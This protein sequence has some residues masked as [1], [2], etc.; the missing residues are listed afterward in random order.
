MITPRFACSQTETSVIASIYCPAIRVR[1]LTR[2]VRLSRNSY[3]KASE[4]EIHV[5]ETLLTVHVAPYF[6]RLNFPGNVVEDDASSAAYDPVSGYLTVTLTKETSGESFPDLDLLAKL[7]APRTSKEN[8]PQRPI[9]EVVSNE[10]ASEPRDKDLV[11][12]TGRLSL[13]ANELSQEQKEILEGKPLVT[14]GT[15]SLIMQPPR[16]TGNYRKRSQ[17][18]C[19]NYILLLRSP[20]A[21]LTPILGISDM[22]ATLRTR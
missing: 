21:S 1:V 5:D 15:R 20:M 12:Q 19:L 7:L 6:L 17:K 9:I 14:L 8:I 11:E 13:D 18:H 22:L 2:F 10:D 3:C 4:V 16:M